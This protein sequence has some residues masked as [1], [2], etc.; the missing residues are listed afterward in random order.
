MT[1]R[2]TIS[3]TYIYPVDYYYYYFTVEKNKKCEGYMYKK[4]NGMCVV[5]EFCTDGHAGGIITI[6]SKKN[7]VVSAKDKQMCRPICS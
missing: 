2:W 4:E 6:S 5:I 7:I 1:L 3:H